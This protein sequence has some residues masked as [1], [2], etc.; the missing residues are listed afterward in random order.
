MWAPLQGLQTC[1]SACCLGSS[2]ERLSQRANMPKVRH[3]TLHFHD[4]FGVFLHLYLPQSKQP[5]CPPQSTCYSMKRNQ[6]III[7]LSL[8]TGPLSK[9]CAYINS[10]H[11]LILLYS[12][13]M[14]QRK[15][16]D[17]HHSPCPWWP[18]TSLFQQWLAHRKCSPAI[19]FTRESIKRKLGKCCF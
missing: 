15:I 2:N 11:L 17:F 8:H 16:N 12:R 14:R 13:T 5:K 1:I 3:I 7:K 19:Y 18:H 9:C 10:V 4:V 6:L